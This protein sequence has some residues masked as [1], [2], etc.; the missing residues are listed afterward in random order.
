MKSDGAMSPSSCA[1]FP[2]T[3]LREIRILQLLNHENVIDLVEVCRSKGEWWS[4]RVCESHKVGVHVILASCVCL[5][6]LPTTERG[7]AYS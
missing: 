1:Q 7:E 4:S 2:M 6:L 5:Q 3:A